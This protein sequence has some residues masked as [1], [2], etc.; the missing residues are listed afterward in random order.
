MNWIE[1]LF[2]ELEENILQISEYPYTYVDEFFETEKSP[3]L[4]EFFY[5]YYLRRLGLRNSPWV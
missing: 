1:G 2:G 5:P 4:S 3:K